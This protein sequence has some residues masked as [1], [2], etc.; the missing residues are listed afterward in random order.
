MK[1]TLLA[2][3]LFVLLLT[4]CKKETP[5]LSPDNALL[6]FQIAAANNSELI[7]N[8]VNFIVN[9]TLVAGISGNRK[10]KVILIANFTTTG[11]AVTVNGVQQVSGETTNDFTNPVIYTV[12]AQNGSL[13][14]YTV[15]LKA[16]TGLPIIYINTD[17]PVVSKEIY[18]NG[19]MKVNGNLDFTDGLY[20]GKIQIRG[21]GNSTWYQ[22]KKPYKIK[23]PSKSGILGMPADKEWALLANY[24]DKTLMRND[25]AFELSERIGLAWTP[26]RRFVEV[27]MNNEYVGNYLLTETVKTG[28]DRLNITTMDIKKPTDTTGDYLAEADYTLNGAQSFRTA[29]TV[30]IVLKEPDPLSDF[31]FTYIQH[32]FQLMEDNISNNL[33]MRPQIDLDSW[34]KWVI[35]N[36]VMRNRDAVFYGSCFFYGKNGKIYMGPVWDFDLSSG[37]YSGNDPQ[38]WYVHNNNWINSLFNYHPYYRERFKQIWSKMYSSIAS[39]NNYIKANNITLQYSQKENFTRWNIMNA[40]SYDGQVM[41]G[42]YQSEVDHLSNFLNQRISWINAQVNSW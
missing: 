38:G 40:S 20:D 13:K 30:S 42:N 1:K 25:V 23:L 37:G 35:V 16:F 31:Q 2:V 3:N 8:D 15:K 19:S 9:D 39:I 18:V 27:I 34:I 7:S 4:A 21:R 17:A 5:L 22:D 28:A 14:R 32:Q 24:F 41:S 11:V 10:S 29:S 36:E 33:D 26:R 6:T 12:T